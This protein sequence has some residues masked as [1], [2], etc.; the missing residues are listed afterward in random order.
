MS[1]LRIL[2]A[3]TRVGCRFDG[4]SRR[5]HHKLLSSIEESSRLVAYAVTRPVF[6]STDQY[7]A[8]RLQSRIKIRSTEQHIVRVFSSSR[9][10]LLFTD[11]LLQNY[12]RQIVAEWNE[13]QKQLTGNKSDNGQLSA[14]HI[15]KRLHFLEP[16]VA[17]VQQHEQH[18][19]D[20]SELEDIISGMC[21]FQCSL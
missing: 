12:I 2:S 20:V 5:I 8:R 16:I 15:S 13:T 10:S 4:V 9:K 21:A 11:D 7:H 19:V 17:K 14:Q 6:Y 1:W 3:C 18:S